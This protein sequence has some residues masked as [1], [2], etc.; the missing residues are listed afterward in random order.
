VWDLYQKKSKLAW[1]GDTRKDIVQTWLEVLGPYLKHFVAALKELAPDSYASL[2]KRWETWRHD[3][4]DVPGWT[5]PINGTDAEY[6]AFFPWHLLVAT[7]RVSSDHVDKHDP[8]HIQG[9]IQQFGLM[10]C[11]TE[12]LFVTSVGGLALS[13]PGELTIV[14]FGRESHHHFKL[15]K[16]MWGQFCNGDC[17][18]VGVHS[19][20]DRLGQ[21]SKNLNL[22]T[23]SFALVITAHKLNASGQDLKNNKGDTKKPSKGAWSDGAELLNFINVARLLYQGIMTRLEED[24]ASW[25]VTEEMKLLLAD[26]VEKFVPEGKDEIEYERIQKITIKKGMDMSKFG[27]VKL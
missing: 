27:I 25:E 24:D 16:E 22:P 19:C 11:H 9:A 6:A 10:Y 23:A 4:G 20:L 13:N 12:G 26:F 7:I 14:C 18:D 2:E 3:G 8:S 5:R 1:T 21:Q 15:K 17:S